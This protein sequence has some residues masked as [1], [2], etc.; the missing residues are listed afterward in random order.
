MEIYVDKMATNRLGS[1]EGSSGLALLT[2]PKYQCVPGR[3]LRSKSS[4]FS[5]LS[6]MVKF[7]SGVLNDS[8]RAANTKSY[9]ETKGNHPTLYRSPIGSSRTRPSQRAS[10]RVQV[11]RHMPCSLHSALFAEQSLSAPSG[12]SRGNVPSSTSPRRQGDEASSREKEVSVSS[13]AARDPKKV[14]SSLKPV[15]QSVS[16]KWEAEMLLAVSSSTAMYVA[17]NCTAPLERARVAKL[18]RDRHAPA[19]SLASEQ[20]LATHQ[21]L[22][23]PAAATNGEHSDHPMQHITLHGGRVPFDQCKEETSEE[24]S[25]NEFVTEL[26]RCLDGLQTCRGG[27]DSPTIVFGKDVK[28]AKQLQEHYPELP[29]QWSQGEGCRVM[30]TG[31]RYSRGHRRWTALPQAVEVSPTIAE[32]IST[33][34]AECSTTWEGYS[35]FL[36]LHG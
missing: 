12:T 11:N 24:V 19:D 4:D 18:A 27:L 26:N 17:E 7:S 5:E 30:D 22:L 3:R 34:T 10:A 6:S 13:P 36:F 35:V 9:A 29:T 2:I 33:S 16:R 1:V 20:K 31:K 23:L 21:P 32:V 28:F 8:T 15:Q 25:G 14:W